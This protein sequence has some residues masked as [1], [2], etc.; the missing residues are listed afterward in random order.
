MQALALTLLNEV[1][2]LH[3]GPVGVGLAAI[4]KST[5]LLTQVIFHNC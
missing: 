5:C 3:Y 4:T 2:D 1:L